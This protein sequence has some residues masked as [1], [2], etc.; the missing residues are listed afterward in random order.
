M[1]PITCDSAIRYDYNTPFKGIPENY[2]YHR[3]IV[4]IINKNLRGNKMSGNIFLIWG[5]DPYLVEEKTAE[6]INKS[7]WTAGK[8]WKGFFWMPMRSVHRSWQ[9]RWNLLRCFHWPGSSFSTSLLA[10][11]E[12]T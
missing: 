11:Q 8:K 1:P 6:I 12:Q 3:F 4:A 2:M 5:Q 7:I 9:R 10:D